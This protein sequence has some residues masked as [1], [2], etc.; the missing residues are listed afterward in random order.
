MKRGNHMVKKAKKKSAPRKKS[1][2]TSMQYNLSAALQEV[3]GA[4]KLTR[5]Q[6]VKKLWDYIKKHKCQDPKKKR[7]IVPD[8]KLA[9]VFGSSRPVDMLKMA[10]L[11]GKHLKKA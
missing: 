5:P 9:E 3:V 10:G 6:V 11:L 4:K 1:G 2:L 8:K 7:M